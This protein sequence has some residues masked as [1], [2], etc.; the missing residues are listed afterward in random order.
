MKHV[1]AFSGGVDST[2]LVLWAK[3]NLPE[4]QAV[5][6]DT[7]WEAV[8][9]YGYIEEINQKLLGGML[10]TLTSKKYPDGMV[11]LVRERKRTPSAKARYCTEELKVFPMIEFVKSI[12]D[13]VTIYQGIRA[14]ESAS[15][16]KMKAREWSDYYDCFVERP[17]FDWSKKRVFQYLEQNKIEPNQMYKLGSSRVGCF[18]CVMINHG[19]LKRL[20]V[21]MPE[22][23]DRI[24]LLE[25]QNGHSFFPP[26]YIPFR[27]QTGFDDKSQKRFPKSEDVYRYIESVDENQLQ[28]FPQSSCMSIYNLCE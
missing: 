11:Q 2:A 20:L 1:I 7:G 15:R 23:K 8:L 13:E 27:F 16:S 21:T 10:I 18:P 25:A 24:R 5:F 22:I 3:E 26:N 6:C 12:D 4:F 17:L 28:M 9:T 14:D 19:E